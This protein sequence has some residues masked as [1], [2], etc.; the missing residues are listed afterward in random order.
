LNKKGINLFIHSQYRH[1]D[2][3]LHDI[4]VALL[5]NCWESVYLGMS[6]YLNR[7]VGFLIGLQQ[8]IDQG[9]LMGFLS[10]H[11]PTTQSHSQ[12][13]TFEITIAL[14]KEKRSMF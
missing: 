2:N 1:L 11:I 14:L 10:Y 3:E 4:D 13:N 8:R 7:N 5:A 9:Y 12:I 6:S